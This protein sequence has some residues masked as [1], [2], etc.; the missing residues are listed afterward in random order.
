MNVTSGAVLLNDV[1][2]ITITDQA[3]TATIGSSAATV[4]VATNYTITM[5]VTGSILSGSRMR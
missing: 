5:A 1:Q 2:N 3:L 4:G